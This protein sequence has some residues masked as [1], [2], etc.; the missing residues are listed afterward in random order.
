MSNSNELA[1]LAVPTN[2][3]LAPMVQ[4]SVIKGAYVQHPHVQ[5]RNFASIQSV[6]GKAPCN[7]GT[8]VL[9]D[10]STIHKLQPFVF[11]MTPYFAQYHAEADMQGNYTQCFPITQQPPKGA[12]E[13]IDSIVL[14]VSGGE[15]GA[16]PTVRPAR[17]R[18][19][20]GKCQLLKTAYEA[21]AALDTKDKKLGALVKSGLAPYNFLTFDASYR[22]ETGKVSKKAYYV[23]NAE[24]MVTTPEL[25]KT[26]V[27]L[28]KNQDFI[29]A[30]NVCVEGHN[31]TLEGVKQLGG[32][33]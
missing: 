31:D 32:M 8:P 1:V 13:V 21:L 19:K 7:E 20:S 26:L 33:A 16:P 6:F 10:G 25:T 3:V 5:A 17:M 28:M 30:Y 24:G 4:V 18:L 2:N 15:D 14:C 22:T 27:A 29:K 9:I 11:L 12:R 23:A